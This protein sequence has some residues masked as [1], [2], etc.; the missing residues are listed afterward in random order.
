MTGFTYKIEKGTKR[1]V[2]E[3]EITN[4]DGSTYAYGARQ[5]T[6][7]DTVAMLK[8]CVDRLNEIIPVSLQKLQYGNRYGYKKNMNIEES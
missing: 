1:G 3:Y 2:W 8:K 4:P 5:S 6:K 7:K